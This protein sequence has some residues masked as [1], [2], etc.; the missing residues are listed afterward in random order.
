MRKTP[1]EMA[2]EMTDFVNT[3]SNEP[4]K[5]FIQAMSNEHRTLQQSFTRLCLEWIEY[6]ASQD[7]RTDGRNES[8]HSTCKAIVEAYKEKQNTLSP[9]STY[10]PFI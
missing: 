4:R 5:E 7:Y 6:C 3:F 2:V 1:K 10:L 9:L 8:S